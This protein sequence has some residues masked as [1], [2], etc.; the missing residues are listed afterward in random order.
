M[1]K[2]KGREGEREREREKGERDKRFDKGQEKKNITVHP[3][4]SIHSYLLKL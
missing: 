4:F 3:K 1:R 2:I